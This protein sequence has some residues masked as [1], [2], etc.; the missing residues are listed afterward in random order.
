[1]ISYIKSHPLRLTVGITAL[2]L[3]TSAY[4]C[5]QSQQASVVSIATAVCNGVAIEQSSSLQTGSKITAVIQAAVAACAATS[6]GTQVASTGADLVAIF[7]ALP[8]LQ[9][10][11]LVNLTALAPNDRALVKRA[12]TLS[13]AEITRIAKTFAN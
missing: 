3:L 13:P 7:A 8:V 12:V 1:M 6:G 5:T 11:G 10:A 4:S 2:A 9:Q